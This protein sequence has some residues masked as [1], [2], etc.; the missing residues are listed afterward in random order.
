[1]G[2]K[3]LRV[4]LVKINL[5]KYIT[6]LDIKYYLVI[7]GMIKFLIILNILYAKKVVLQEA[8]IIISQEAELIHI[9]LYL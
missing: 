6:K 2:S 5:L 4:R 7:G 3:P 9:I 8:I 1:M